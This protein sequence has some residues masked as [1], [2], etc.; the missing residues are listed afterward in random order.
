[1]TSRDALTGRPSLWRPVCSAL[2]LAAV[3]GTAFLLWRLVAA[4]C[5]ECLTLQGWRAWHDPLLDFVRSNP[6]VATV[7]LFVLHVL[8]AMLAMPGAS[9]LMLVAGAGLGPL[10]GTLL[11][12]TAC[13]AGTSLSMLA[14]RHFLQPVVRRKMGARLAGLERRVASDGAAYLFSLRLLPLI[15]FALLN[16]V[17]G[18]SG[19]RAWTFTW[20]SFVGMLAGTFVYVNVGSQLAAIEMVGDIYSPRVLLSLAALAFLPW[21]LKI[22]HGTW[23][24]RAG[25]RA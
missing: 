1:M 24:R 17:A 10:A 11:C 20:V 22:L 6:L 19:M 8:L 5:P 15:P 16:V 9:L 4:A 12:L 3:A 7:M 23:Q 21:A 2:L 14:V 25:A 13:T 18:L